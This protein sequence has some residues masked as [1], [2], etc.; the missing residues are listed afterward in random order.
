MGNDKCAKELGLLYK[1]HA[2]LYDNETHA[3][4]DR[5]LQ[6]FTANVKFNFTLL[7]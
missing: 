5:E 6:G 4:P 2:F 7:D 3:Y 1:E